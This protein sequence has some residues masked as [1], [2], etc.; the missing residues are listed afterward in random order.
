MIKM[1]N[2]AERPEDAGRIRL[3]DIVGLYH[4]LGRESIFFTAFHKKGN[5][6]MQL[7]RRPEAAVWVRQ[8]LGRGV[9]CTIQLVLDP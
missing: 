4:I 6:Y 2:L 9:I 8:A 3:F 1:E 7:Q 5:Q